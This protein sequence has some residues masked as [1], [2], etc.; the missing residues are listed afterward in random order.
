MHEV[1]LVQ[2]VF[3]DV[4]ESARINGVS[5]ITKVKLVIGRDCL[6]LPGALLFAFEQLKREPLTPDAEL[7]I[8]ERTGRD[9]YIDYYEGAP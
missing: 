7:V 6:V 8:E 5:R 2:S 9:L 4:A 3:K 1:S